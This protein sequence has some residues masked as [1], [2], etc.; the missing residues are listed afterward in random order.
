ML[1]Y[2]R[3]V[4]PCLKLQSE[5]VCSDEGFWNGK[6]AFKVALLPKL[7][8][9]SIAAAEGAVATGV[10][11]EIVFFHGTGC[12]WSPYTAREEVSEST[13][14]YIIPLKSHV[15]VLMSYHKY[16]LFFA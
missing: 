11:T 13:V 1:M 8:N 3:F 12:I 15:A 10:D 5:G 9:A 2:F 6:F 4:P 14:S 7:L 16:R